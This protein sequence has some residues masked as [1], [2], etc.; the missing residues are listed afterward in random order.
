M[1]IFFGDTG[2]INKNCLIC[3]EEGE[4]F[5][6]KSIGSKFSIRDSASNNIFVFKTNMNHSQIMNEVEEKFMIN[7]R[8]IENV[9]WKTNKIEGE[10][11]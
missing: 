4:S 10:F 2:L 6:S 7:K 8:F 11:D 5:A 3:G 9:T 1:L